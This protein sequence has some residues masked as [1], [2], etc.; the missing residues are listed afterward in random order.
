M[1][2]DSTKADEVI[3]QLTDVEPDESPQAYA[4]FLYWANLPPSERFQTDTMDHVAE[5][6]GLS[7]VT[8]KQYRASF[9]WTERIKLIDAHFARIQFNQRVEAN[10][11]HNL[12]FAA[13]TREIQDKAL[14]LSKQVLGVVEMLVETAALGSKVHETDYVQALQ[15]DGT[16]KTVPRTTQVIMEAKVSDIA[17][18]LR[19][20]VDVPM[21]VAGLPIETVPLE[22]QTMEGDFTGKTKAELEEMRRAIQKRKNKLR[23]IDQQSDKIN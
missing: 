3:R 23:G 21:K 11:E 20:G 14:K 19:A 2:F 18:L 9:R 10:R 13:D 17:L 15:K 12:K 8:V 22:S 4:A 7:L 16:H 1:S 5:Y 6:A